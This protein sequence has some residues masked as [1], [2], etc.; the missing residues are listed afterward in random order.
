MQFIFLQI[1]SKSVEFDTGGGVEMF[2]RK[3]RIRSIV[4]KVKV[5]EPFVYIVIKDQIAIVYAG[6]F[7]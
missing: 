4:K 7:N 1:N 6:L 2:S 3:R 5:D